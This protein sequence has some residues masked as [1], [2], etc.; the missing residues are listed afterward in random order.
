MGNVL[1]LDWFEK[2]GYLFDW[3]ESL[4]DV[5]LENGN[6]NVLNWF[7][8]SQYEFNYSSNIKI[9][10]NNQAVLEWLKENI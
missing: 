8:K 7:R 5:A 6:I 3:T 9:K 2:S 10:N 1:I 4:I